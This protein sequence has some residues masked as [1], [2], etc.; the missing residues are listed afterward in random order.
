MPWVKSEYAPELAVLSAWIAA[1]V[2]WSVTVH[3][4]APLGSVL[5]AIRFPLAEIQVRAAS[6]VTVDGQTVRVTDVLDQVYPGVGVW[7]DAYLADPI[8]AAAT[9]DPVALQVGSAAWAL[10]A[11]L[12]ALAVVLGIA[13]YRDEAATA[14]RLPYDEVRVMGGLLAGASLAF[15]AASALYY[16]G[17][18]V[19]GVPVPIGVL[20]VGALAVALLRIDRV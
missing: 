15:A 6:T 11:V 16:L 9:Y 4:A 17:R 10:G 2:P 3:T 19:V 18:D 14:R 12:I 7:G 13:M 8:S 20:L 1:L 5:F